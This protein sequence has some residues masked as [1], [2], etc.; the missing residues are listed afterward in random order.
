MERNNC[1]DKADGPI[2]TKLPACCWPSLWGRRG[3][4]GGMCLLTERD[5]GRQMVRTGESAWRAEGTHPLRLEQWLSCKCLPGSVFSS[6]KSEKQP[7]FT[8]S[9]SGE[10][11]EFS[12][13][14]VNNT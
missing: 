10:N 12:A 9:H 14:S 3:A 13:F 1:V 6:I 4:E 5:Q 7:Y 11:L 8:D 2:D